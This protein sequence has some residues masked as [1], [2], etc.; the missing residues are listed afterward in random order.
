M[1]DLNADEGEARQSSASSSAAAPTE[2]AQT[3]MNLSLLDPPRW[4]WAAVGGV[5]DLLTPQEVRNEMLW[6]IFCA[7]LL[8]SC[9]FFILFMN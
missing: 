8:T 1:K 7:K 6:I 3:S 2:C 5:V 9:A 4:G